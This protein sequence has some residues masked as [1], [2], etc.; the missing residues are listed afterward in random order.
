MLEQNEK[1]KQGFN[2]L[3]ILNAQSRQVIEGADE[4]SEG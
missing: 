4:E 3:V 1:Q 2:G